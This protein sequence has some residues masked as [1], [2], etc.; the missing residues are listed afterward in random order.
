MALASPR[1]MNASSAPASC[2]APD[3]DARVKFTPPAASSL[4]IASSMPERTPLSCLPAPVR[5]PVVDGQCE[6]TPSASEEG[7]EASEHGEEE[8]GTGVS[9]S[10]TVARSTSQPFAGPPPPVKSFAAELFEALGEQARSSD[11]DD[12]CFAGEGGGGR[13]GKFSAKQL[14]HALVLEDFEMFVCIAPF[15]PWAMVRFSSEKEKRAANV[16]A[17]VEMFNMVSFW[18]ASTVCTEE[19]QVG[20][21]RIISFFI[22]MITHCLGV[23]DYNAA[24]MISAG[25]NNIAVS[26]LKG[27]W[28]GLSKAELS[29]WDDASSLLDSRNNYARYRE[30]LSDN[31]SAVVPF[32]GV[33]LRDLTFIDDGNGD[34]IDD[35]TVNSEKVHMVGQALDSL[36]RHQGRVLPQLDVSH[37]TQR[38]ISS[39]IRPVP[40]E[41]DEWL[42]A[43]SLERRP[44]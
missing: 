1:P 19:S 39:A 3:A 7:S 31:P 36:L 29:A 4:S 38:F 42:Y 15:E 21:T 20:R 35:N 6:R 28:E 17:Q 5:D 12:A 25:L 33:V 30:H 24:M 13:F 34:M 27:S 11:Q 44:L 23:G 18:V 2:D 41:S 40:A 26:R 8:V 32:L 43:Q 10:G 16:M 22:S 14:A 9:T 37:D